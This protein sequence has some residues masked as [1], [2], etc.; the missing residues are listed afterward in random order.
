VDSLVHELADPD[1][2]RQEVALMVLRHLP[3]R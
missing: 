1:E 3:L 2:V